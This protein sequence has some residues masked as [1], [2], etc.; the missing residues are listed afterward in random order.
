MRSARRSLHALLTL[1]VSGTVCAQDATE[2]SAVGDTLLNP[3]SIR[4]TGRFEMPP[5]PSAAEVAARSLAEQ[6]KRKA[7]ADAARSPLEPLLKYL[8][9]E[10]GATMNSPLVREDDAFFTPAYMKLSG[11]L[12]DRE[13]AAQDRRG[14]LLLGR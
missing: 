1:L 5:G 11:R 14:T 9:G 6:I 3:A 13:L 4:I 7:D 12:L 2:E 8:P 10:A